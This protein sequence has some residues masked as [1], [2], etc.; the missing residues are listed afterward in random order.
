MGKKRLYSCVGMMV[1]WWGVSLMMLAA[2][3]ASGQTFSAGVVSHDGASNY[4]AP[5]VGISHSSG[6]W[7]FSGQVE[8]ASREPVV[9]ASV[10]RRFGRLGDMESY[11]GPEMLQDWSVGLSLDY[12]KNA[13]L[14]IDQRVQFA[15]ILGR[16]VVKKSEGQAWEV[17]AAFGPALEWVSEDR[18]R[19]CYYRQRNGGDRYCRPAGTDG[20]VSLRGIAMVSA[21]RAIHDGVEFRAD[22]RLDNALTDIADHRISG[23]IHI[24]ADLTDDV[25]LDTGIRLYT[26]NRPANNCQQQDTAL[27][28]TLNYRW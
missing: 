27:F 19:R 7:G 23:S 5:T 4:S 18:V 9:E 10:Q 12:T 3:T 22:A 11:T 20:D 17:G 24:L 16:E 6:D 14:R 28:S 2:T 13:Y 15:G 26:D 1:V 21:A 8:L 25:S